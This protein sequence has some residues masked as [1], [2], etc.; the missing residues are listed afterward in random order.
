MH[1]LEKA[2]AT[3]DDAL[4]SHGSNVPKGRAAYFRFRLA[5]LAMRFWQAVQTCATRRLR[6]ST[7][8]ALAAKRI[9][10]LRAALGAACRR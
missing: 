6:Q 3:P 4:T 9:L 2:P 1:P 7:N 8:D 10:D 5:L